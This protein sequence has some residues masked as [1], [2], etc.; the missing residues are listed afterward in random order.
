[1][2]IYRTQYSIIPKILGI[3]TKVIWSETQ[4]M[5]ASDSLGSGIMRAFSV[6]KNKKLILL[7]IRKNL[8]LGLGITCHNLK[9]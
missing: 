9:Y 7:K 4:K 8:Y 5:N 3:V 6:K 1:M 2:W